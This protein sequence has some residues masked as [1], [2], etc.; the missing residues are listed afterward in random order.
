MDRTKIVKPGCLDDSPTF[1]NLPETI[2]NDF[3]SPIE[4]AG[5]CDS[6]LLAINDAT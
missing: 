1:W 5:S 2:E 6:L 4:E 3:V